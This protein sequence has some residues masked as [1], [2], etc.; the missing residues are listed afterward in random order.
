MTQI[1]EI[2][3][4]E[5]LLHLLFLEG[6]TVTGA[7]GQVVGVGLYLLADAGDVDINRAGIDNDVIGRYGL[8]VRIQ[9]YAFV[10]YAVTCG[11][12]T[13]FNYVDDV[14]SVLFA[15]YDMIS[16]YGSVIVVVNVLVKT[17]LRPADS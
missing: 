16:E 15:L 5:Q 14:V 8:A 10:T 7:C 4:K 1:Y 17:S 13:G 6:V 12:Q 9:L 3:P 2:T 11:A